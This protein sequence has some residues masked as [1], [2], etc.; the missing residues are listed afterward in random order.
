MIECF[1]LIARSCYPEKVSFTR[2]RHPNGVIFEYTDSGDACSRL[3]ESRTQQRRVGKYKVF[4]KTSCAWTGRLGVSGVF[5]GSRLARLPALFHARV[6]ATQVHIKQTHANNGTQREQPRTS[7]QASTSTHM[8]AQS[9]TRKAQAS[10]SK[11]KQAQA[12]TS[13]HKPAQASLSTH[14]QA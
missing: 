3:F 14:R 1:S 2:G 12:S 11:L 5:L 8:Q 9:I 7:T 4:S 10:T 13:Q 6:N